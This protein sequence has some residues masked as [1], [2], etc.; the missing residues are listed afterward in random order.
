[1]ARQPLHV[2]FLEGDPFSRNAILL[3]N[4]AVKMG[5]GLVPPPDSREDLPQERHRVLGVVA[6]GLHPLEPDRDRTAQA[7]GP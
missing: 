3:I 4:D 1:M 5:Q 2:G 6:R 7:L